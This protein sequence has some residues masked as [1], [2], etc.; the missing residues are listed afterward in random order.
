MIKNGDLYCDFCHKLIRNKEGRG[1][2]RVITQRAGKK[3][4]HFCNW[5]CAY[6]G[7]REKVS[8]SLKPIAHLSIAERKELKTR[9]GY[10][11][12]TNVAHTLNKNEVNAKKF[13]EII[14]CDN[15]SKRRDEFYALFKYENSA[16]V[17]WIRLMNWYFGYSEKE[18]DAEKWETVE[19]VHR[20]YSIT[21]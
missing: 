13:T 15:P 7:E 20:V 8:T 18:L 9:L 10:S 2:G 5:T 16:D 1:G 17:L 21:N 4:K 12:L 6:K 11:M 3:K 19:R 14:L